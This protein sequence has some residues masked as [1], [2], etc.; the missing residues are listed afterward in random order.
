MAKAYIT[1]ENGRSFEGES[2]GAAGE[3]IGEI[4]FTTGV[5]GYIETISDPSYYGQIIVHTFP[6]I[7]N[8]GWIDA[9]MESGGCAASAVV[10]RE[11]C[12][13]P[14]NFR[15]DGTLDGFL[16]SRGII[17]VW[18]VDT[19]ELTR[20]IREHG[21]MNAMIT[22][23]RPREIPP[24]LKDYR[25]ENAVA[26]T[27]AAASAVYEPEG[28]PLKDVA[29]MDYGA[30]Y[31]IIR[32]LQ[33]RGCRV[34]VFPQDT[35]AAEVLMSG[36]DGIMLSNGPGDPEENIYPI[37]QLRELMGKKPVFGICLGHQ[38]MAL[39]M[40]GKTAKLKYGHRGANQPVKELST[41]RVYITSQNHG[42]HVLP[43]NLESMG[44]VLTHVNANDG[45]CEGLCYPGK[46]AFS[47]Q[48]HPEAHAG[49][50]DTVFAFDRFIDLMNGG[51]VNA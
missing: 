16:K 22:H 10:V 40:G 51:Q 21:V 26:S 24:A 45:S 5:V 43:E 3:T 42:Y 41:D 29:L 46:N 23:E 6:Q 28:E 36:S 34:T 7:G 1:L 27:S 15:S 44:A 47:M 14:S 50:V 18:G 9:D 11:Y 39:A 37:E 19:R 33:K 17:G 48:F 4:V 49:P 32:E 31:N 35:P 25:V 2:F 13:M 12:D 20:I 8:Y 38:L 30:K